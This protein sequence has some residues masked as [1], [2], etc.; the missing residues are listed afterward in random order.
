MWLECGLTIWPSKIVLRGVLLPEGSAASSDV[1]GQAPAGPFSLC[2]YIHPR[3]ASFFLYSRDPQRC[4]VVVSVD[5]AGVSALEEV[6]MVITNNT[7]LSEI[8]SLGC[9]LENHAQHDLVF[10]TRGSKSRMEISALMALITNSMPSCLF[11]V[12]TSRGLPSFH[13]W[14]RSLLPLSLC[15]RRC[16]HLGVLPSSCPKLTALRPRSDLTYIYITRF[17]T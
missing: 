14:V 1:Q 11:H 4:R 6:L 7:E 12:L 13:Q 5:S 17:H 15:S 8:H 10:F 3:A 2:Y 9:L 16:P